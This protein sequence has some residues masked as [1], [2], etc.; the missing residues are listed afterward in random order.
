MVNTLHVTMKILQVIM[1][2]KQVI[3]KVVLLES[4]SGCCLC[5]SIWDTTGF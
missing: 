5:Y 1:M 3:A 4:R 2:D